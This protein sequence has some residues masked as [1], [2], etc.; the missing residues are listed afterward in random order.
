MAWFVKFGSLFWFGLVTS[1]SCFGL[2]WSWLV[3]N[4]VVMVWFWFSSFPLSCVDV[5]CGFLIYKSVG[6][7][8]VT[9]VWFSC[10]LNVL[11]SSGSTSS[12]FVPPSWFGFISGLGLLL[13]AFFN[14]PVIVCWFLRLAWVFFLGLVSEVCLVLRPLL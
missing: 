7:F 3:S 10:F 2:I 1:I 6:G 8:S 11:L 13:I 9:L 14:M 5:S 12:G 4:L